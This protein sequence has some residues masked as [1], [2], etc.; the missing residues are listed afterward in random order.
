MDADTHG[1]PPLELRSVFGFNGEETAG[2]RV[3][4]CFLAELSR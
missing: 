4:F 2:G 1:L 3:K